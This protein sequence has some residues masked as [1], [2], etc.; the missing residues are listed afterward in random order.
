VRKTELRAS[1]CCNRGQAGAL[2][3]ARPRRSYGNISPR[4]YDDRAIA[5]NRV[6]HDRMRRG[7]NSSV[8]IVIAGV[9][10]SW[11]GC[12][13]MSMLTKNTSAEGYRRVRSQD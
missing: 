4:L 3:G 9:M 5:G 10:T 6:E 8:L 2:V 7:A 12:L 1:S 11:S 13:E